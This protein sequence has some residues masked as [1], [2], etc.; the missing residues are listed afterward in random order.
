MDLVRNSS[1]PTLA[2][3]WSALGDALTSAAFFMNDGHDARRG[4]RC[5]L[6]ARAEGNSGCD[7]A[8]TLYA[9]ACFR[10]LNASPRHQANLLN[11]SF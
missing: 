6:R 7:A 9:M 10:V 8:S 4:R 2:V 11:A 1:T 3:P 5:S